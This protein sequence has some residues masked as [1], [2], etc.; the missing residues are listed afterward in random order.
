MCRR[1]ILVYVTA[2]LVHFFIH[3]NGD[4]TSCYV[5]VLV[6]R[7]TRYQV[8]AGMSQTLHCPVKY[9]AGTL[10]N[11]SWCKYTGSA[12]ITIQH[13]TGRINAKW[14][15]STE[16]RYN[17]DFTLS[18][19][20]AELNDTGM[21]RCKA[22]A[23][24]G[25]SS[26][27]HA[28]HLNVTTDDVAEHVNITEPPETSSKKSVIWQVYV[29]A[30]L[31]TFCLVIFTSSVILCINFRTSKENDVNSNETAQEESKGVASAVSSCPPDIFASTQ[32]AQGS[33]NYSSMIGLPQEPRE[34]TVYDNDA[35][36][37]WNHI[38]TAPPPCNTNSCDLSSSFTDNNGV[39]VYAA[40][41]HPANG[42]GPVRGM[43][44][45]L[46]EYAAISVK[47]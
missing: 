25:Q 31:G 45:E 6:E 47:D 46:T 15:T 13:E 20:L 21:Y 38:P 43:T 17:G 33:P 2:Y 3:V 29:Y 16:T 32:N 40:L 24:S 27:G 19:T 37:S 22:V 10:A 35:L 12:C 5:D 41:N 39:L 4:E 26:V 28:I 11:A 30:S 7:N 34:E 36:P 42:A 9:C 44:S 14:I 18:I 23:L 8:A 1:Q